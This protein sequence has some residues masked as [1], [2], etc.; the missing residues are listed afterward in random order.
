MSMMERT[1]QE[2][3]HV[4]M[5]GK[6]ILTYRGEE[7]VLGRNTTG[8]FIQLL[9][10]V[11]LQGERGISKEQLM[12]AL[13][14]REEILNINNSFN[15]LLYQLKKQIKLTGLPD[16]EYILKKNNLYMTGTDIP[17]Q[18]DAI[19]FERVLENAKTQ[20]GEAERCRLCA[21]ALE[22]YKGE[23]LPAISTELWVVE[24]SLRLK[25]LYEESVKWV[26]GYLKKQREYQEACRL[27]AQAAALYPFDEWQ[28]DQIE[29]LISMGAF[30]E[31]VLLYDKT[32]EL[33]S[34]EIGIP[35]SDRMLRCYKEMGVQIKNSPGNMAE[36][37]Q[38][39]QSV[40]LQTGGEEEHK[41][42]GA[43]YCSYPGFL[44]VYH[45][46]RRN[47]ERT[48]FSIYLILCTL[49]DYEGKMIQNQDKLKTRSAFLKKA[50]E[51]T[52]REGDSYTKYSNSQYLLLLVGVKKED[53][54]TV[55]QRIGKSFKALA[56]PRAELKFNEVSLAEL[57]K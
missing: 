21:R 42:A 27:Y 13:Y 10:L 46:L 50:I 33:Y 18:I 20:T 29:N 23:L 16:G 49:V 9:L 38:V 3:I 30:K 34:T 57:S 22:L 28:V 45:M 17:V 36:I 51:T 41:S 25:Q 15:N 5:F 44:D 12:Q 26:G 19:E 7:Y 47:M 6:F 55:Y 14:D 56:G 52:L 8:K 4:R 35:P 40:P 48:G 37:M 31:A 43:Y 1:E 32:V 24:E 54:E 39:M 11:W 53:C 2:F